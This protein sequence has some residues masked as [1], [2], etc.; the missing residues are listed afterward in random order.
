MRLFLDTATN[1]NWHYP[2][3]G[4]PQ[5]DDVQPHM[6]RLAWSLED[7]SGL[8][9]YACHMVQVPV[10]VRMAQK[11]SD[12][13]G[14]HDLDLLPPRAVSLYSVLSEF[15]EALSAATLLI[16]HNW[17]HHRMVLERELRKSDEQ[18]NQRMWDIRAGGVQRVGMPL[19]WPDA[20][21]TMDAL[22]TIVR[23]ERMTPGGGYQWPRFA[24]ASARLLGTE[25][26]KTG[27]PQADGIQRL[28]HLRAFYAAIQRQEREAKI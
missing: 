3:K 2:I 14:I 28:V 4:T 11:A 26:P 24:Q 25:P 12:H 16:S 7:D 8:H 13:T 5:P 1:D 15:C 20:L 19:T 6:T 22:T 9:R 23:V 10:G 17:T 27:N 21:C 18:G